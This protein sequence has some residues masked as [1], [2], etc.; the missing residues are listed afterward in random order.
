MDADKHKP[1]WADT[2]A[3]RR[4]FLALLVVAALAAAALGLVP[5]F[6]KDHPHFEV[7]RFPFFFAVWGF[8]S[9][10][11]IVLAGQH[12]RKLVARDENYYDERE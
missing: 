11:F 6:Q 4:F 1:G 7:E 5:A 10:M 3:F 2:K 12:L 9:F 8:V